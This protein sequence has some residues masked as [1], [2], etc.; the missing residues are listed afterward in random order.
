MSTVYEA[1]DSVGSRKV[2]V[3]LFASPTVS[4]DFL[5]EA[6]KRECESLRD[7]RHPNVVEFIDVGTDELTG[8]SYLVLEWLDDSLSRRLQTDRREGRMWEWDYF[9]E[10]IGLPILEALAYIHNRNIAHRDV[11]PGNILL[12]PDG[13]G[14]LADFGICKLKY[15]LTPG[16]TLAEFHSPLY[17]P[18]GPIEAVHDYSRDV[19]GFGMIVLTYLSETPPTDHADIVKS[20][21]GL[22]APN[23]IRKLI[24]RAVSLDAAERPRT[25]GVLLSELTATYG[26][27][28][29][30]SARRP[31]YLGITQ[32]A[33]ANVEA[34]LGV[35]GR[36]HAEKFILDDLNDDPAVRRHRPTPG[37]TGVVSTDLRFLLLG[38]Q[39]RYHAVVDRDEKNKLVIMNAFRGSTPAAHERQK[40]DSF[41]PALVFRTGRPPDAVDARQLL[42]DLENDV[43]AFV[44][45]LKLRELQNREQRLMQSWE[46]ILRAKSR[47][48]QERRRPLPYEAVRCDGQRASFTLGLAPDED[49]VGEDRRVELETGRYL[50]GQIESVDGVRLTLYVQ[51][52]NPSDLRPRGALLVDTVADQESLRRQQTALDAVRYDQA[53][54]P[55]LRR[56][57]VDPGTSLLATTEEELVPFQKKLDEDKQRVARK[58]LQTVD[59]LGVEGPPG[60]GKTTLIAEIVLQTLSRQPDARILLTSQTRVALDNALQKIAELKPDLRLV[61]VGRAGEGRSA[62]QVQALTLDPQLDA[63]R[64]EAIREGRGFIAAWATG[65]A[66]PHADI[67]A[68]TLIQELAASLRAA[69]RGRHRMLEEQARLA[70]LENMQGTGVVDP[71]DAVLDVDTELAYSRAEVENL[72][73]VLHRLDK[74]IARLRGRLGSNKDYAELS[75]ASAEEL[76]HWVTML[77]P[78][79]KESKAF[80]AMLK[81]HAEWIERFGNDRSF[82]AAVI[83]RAQVVAGTCIGMMAVRGTDD[84]EYDLCIIDEASKATPTEALVPMSRS[85]RWILVGDE[86]QLPPF[87]D[88]LYQNQ[89]L[90][91]EF[92]LKREEVAESLFG[93][94]LKMLPTECRE[95][96]T[97]QHRMVR[98]IGDLISTCFYR[99][100]LKS[101]DKP[102]DPDLAAVLP[103]P[104]TWFTT[105]S[106]PSRSEQRSQ[107]SFTNWAEAQVIRGFLR[108]LNFK[109]KHRNRKYSVAVISGYAAQRKTITDLVRSE[110]REWQQL[111]VEFNTVDAIQGRDADIAVYS[112]TR[113]N[114]GE[115]I[116]FLRAR[117]RLNVALSRGKVGLVIVGDHQFIRSVGGD[118]PIRNVLEYVESRPQDC[119]IKEPAL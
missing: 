98:P 19:F 84:I 112:I 103:R 105:S 92:G 3:K 30:M 119:C 45:E 100:T 9:S 33:V 88:E 79:T 113:S 109:A 116:G 52:G 69:A 67:E 29:A 39:F 81:L 73:N 101:T 27:Q 14:K 106:M 10:A 107:S 25:A 77:L 80:Q 63:W 86:N 76:E 74:E 97:L 42:A 7:H 90:R 1:F 37:P 47:L 104:V 83:E 50:H 8:R 111:D 44:A 110:L 66:V 56:L 78:D 68:A 102:L 53:L 43:E 46:A 70:K 11:K 36:P 58:A 71:P 64:S 13:R 96:L 2:A 6:F 5:A 38:G 95:T 22:R 48:E 118:N 28:H 57:L 91:E 59:F 82:N 62:E 12:T 99:G 72:D 108:M 4:V 15:W 51:H 23:E 16:V 114:E 61:R 115:S 26:R 93:R 32:T 18:P 20:L 34:E 85:T 87:R 31:C 65:H 21:A 40:E 41:H 49:L 89:E 35:E 55:D 75:D 24:E 54:R 17:S 94:L 60:T 117:E